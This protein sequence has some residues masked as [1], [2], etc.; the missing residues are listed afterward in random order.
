MEDSSLIELAKSWEEQASP[1]T[2]KMEKRWKRNKRYWLGYEKNQQGSVEEEKSIPDNLIFESIETVL[3]VATKRPPEPVVDSDG[4][5]EGTDLAND[6]TK[7]LTYLSKKTKLKYVIK[8][9]TRNWMI[10]ELGVV[11][12]GWDEIENEITSKTIKT[13][14]LILDPKAY[15]ENGRYKGRFI[16]ELREDTAEDLIARFPQAEAQIMIEA[17]NKKNTNIKYTEWWTPTTLF[18]KMKDTILGKAKNPHWNENTTEQSV[19]EYGQSVEMPVE[20]NNHFAAPE[21]PYLFLSVF[22]TGGQPHDETGLI[23]QNIKNQD[24]VVKRIEQIDINADNTN[25]GAVV[26]GDFFTKE[27]ASLVGQ[28]KRKGDTVWVPHGDVNQAYKQDIGASLP[29][30]VYQSL[31]DYRNELRANFGTQGITAQGTAQESTVR[32]K[33]IQ[34]DQDSTR[35]GGGIS[36]YI[37]LLSENIFDWYIQLICVYYDEPHFAISIGE[38][39]AQLA[40][41]VQKDRVNR[42]LIVTVK[43]GSML[44][45]DA[46]TIR[47]Q[48]IDLWTAGLL[49]PLSVYEMIDLP[50]PEETL[51]RLITWQTNPAG[52]LG[53][54]M[55]PGMLP[56]P[57]MGQPSPVTAVPEAPMT[58]QTPSSEAV[59]QQFNAMPTE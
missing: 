31:M 37:E 32:G 35:I 15:I 17:Q 27:Q 36:D 47:N 19:D 13:S 24:L 6:I 23:S 1:Y 50:N 56:Q 8:D 48:A 54:Q 21:M 58:S 57:Q 46:V 49:D 28:A 40:V 34:R 12:V 59:Q 14:S 39:R 52:L 2:A 33:I 29:P 16:G 45:K 26:S 44:P 20:G 55:P 25:G 22:S 41:A 4:T 43:E 7:T 10:Y 38:S 53:A 51:Q 30:F 5:P 42:K 9:A 3:P 18:W 11:K